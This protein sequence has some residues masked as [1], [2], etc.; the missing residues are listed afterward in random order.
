LLGQIL[1][2]FFAPSQ[3]SQK[4][5]NRLIVLND[6][7]LPSRFVAIQNPL[8]QPFVSPISHCPRLPSTNLEPQIQQMVQPKMGFK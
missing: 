4:P 7:L 5:K 2:V 1:S 3:V 6:K 8:H